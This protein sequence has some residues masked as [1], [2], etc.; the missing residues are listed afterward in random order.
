MISSFKYWGKIKDLLQSRSAL[1]NMIATS[2]MWLFTLKFKLIK[3]KK[4]KTK[5]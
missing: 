4:I 1:S 2:H 3:I 5:M